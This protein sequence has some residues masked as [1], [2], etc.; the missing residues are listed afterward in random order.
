[1]NTKHFEPEHEKELTKAELRKS[2]LTFSGPIIAELML[3]SMISMVNLSMVGHLGAY[4]LSSVGLTNQPVLICLAVFQSFNVG[5]TALISRF[6]G[7]KEDREV[8]SVVIQ[9]IN[10]SIISGGVLALF[11]TV[12]S[13]QIVLFLGAQ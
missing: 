7:A 6:I 12:F 3:M 9:T 5:A 1:M 2:I 8:K 10:T 11:G 13:R 4:A